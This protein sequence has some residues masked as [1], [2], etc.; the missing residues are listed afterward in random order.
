MSNK[1]KTAATV[2]TVIGVIVLI[3]L[4]LMWLTDAMLTGDTDVNAP[5]TFIQNHFANYTN[6]A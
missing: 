5:L 2:G 3:V 1:K 6:I 4:L